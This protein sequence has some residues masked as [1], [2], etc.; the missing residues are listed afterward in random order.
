MH[1]Y[2]LVTTSAF[3]R[4]YKKLLKRQYDM[5]LLNEIVE[6]LQDG[7]TLPEKNKDHALTGNWKGY[8]ECHITPDWLLVY[9]VYENTLILSL[10]RTGSHS[11]LDF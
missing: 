7:K 1:K 6:L 8:R 3:K 2:Q 10:S 9:R 4:D 11:D 5:A